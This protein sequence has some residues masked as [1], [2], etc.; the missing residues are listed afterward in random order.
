MLS[1]KG[2]RGLKLLSSYKSLLNRNYIET[3]SKVESHTSKWKSQQKTISGCPYMH[4]NNLV[5]ISFPK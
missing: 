1:H 3:L 4:L 2:A 5:T